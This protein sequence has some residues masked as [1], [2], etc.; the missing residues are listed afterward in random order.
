MSR[1][2]CER[3]DLSACP[4]ITPF[5]RRMYYLYDKHRI[6]SMISDNIGPFFEIV[7]EL[8]FAGNFG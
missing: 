4:I 3:N 7:V 5:V 6:L 2:L 8:L 1:A